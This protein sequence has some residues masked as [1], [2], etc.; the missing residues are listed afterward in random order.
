VSEV[1]VR[2]R[3]IRAARFCARGT[4]A[5]FARQGWDWGR[6]LSEGI[7]AAT[8]E[9]SGDALAQ[10]VARIAREEATGGQQ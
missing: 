6:F 5:F 3:H 7:S 10:R 1:R 2:M 9:A 4:R 8:M